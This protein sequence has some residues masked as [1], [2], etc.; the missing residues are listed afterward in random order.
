MAKPKPFKTGLVR[1]N[2]TKPVMIY[3]RSN[4]MLIASTFC[5]N[6][7]VGGAVIKLAQPMFPSINP[8][9]PFMNQKARQHSVSFLGV[10]YKP[11]TAA[12]KLINAQAINPTVKDN[13]I[14][15]S[16]LSFIDA[17]ALNVNK[18]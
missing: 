6:S 1:V 16:I 14:G 3:S 12:L 18:T 15:G 8:Q 13:T 17:F 9:I 11:A 2:K 7:I 10:K 5:R 4:P